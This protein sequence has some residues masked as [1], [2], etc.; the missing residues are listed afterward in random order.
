[1]PV[2]TKPEDKPAA[3]CFYLNSQDGAL[4][5]TC[6]S[7]GDTEKPPYSIEDGAARF[8]G[9]EEFKAKAVAA[10]MS[11]A[12]AEDERRSFNA[13]AR[14]LREL[15]FRVHVKEEEKAA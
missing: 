12:V 4:S 6:S 13:T 11:P 1:M 5:V 2:D 10:G 14:Q 7:I 15:G 3:V 9:R 8:A